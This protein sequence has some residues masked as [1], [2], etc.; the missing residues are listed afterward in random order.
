MSMHWVIVQPWD[1][2]WKHCY[3]PYRSMTLQLCLIYGAWELGFCTC[4]N[5]YS[6][7]NKYWGH[8]TNCK[9][10]IYLHICICV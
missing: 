5:G 4:L 8:S 1:N 10:N 2:E 7:I 6:H 9:Q 3:S